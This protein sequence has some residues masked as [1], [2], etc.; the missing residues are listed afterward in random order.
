MRTRTKSQPKPCAGCMLMSSTHT[1]ESDTLK[2]F[3]SSQRAEVSSKFRLT[4]HAVESGKLIE[5][6]PD[7]HV[8][9]DDEIDMSKAMLAG[10]I[11]KLTPPASAH[12]SQIDA[13][14]LWLRQN[15]ARAVRVMPRAA[16]DR[17][18]VAAAPE[19]KAHQDRTMREVALERARRV[20]TSVDLPALVELVSEALDQGEV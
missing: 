17:Q 2:A 12:P 14:D 16:D 11:V 18:H 5:F 7:H 1:C 13:F 20:T 4:R 10:C 19:A 6:G 3:Q 9:R 8:W 15:G